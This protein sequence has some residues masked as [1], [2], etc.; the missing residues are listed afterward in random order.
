MRSTFVVWFYIGVLL[1]VY[2][3]ILTLAGIYQWHHPPSTV[4]SEV[5][6][7]FW[8]GVTLSLAGAT[9]VASYWPRDVKW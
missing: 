4:L 8:V 5:H 7:T 1:S 3:V 9:Y 2:G 6:A